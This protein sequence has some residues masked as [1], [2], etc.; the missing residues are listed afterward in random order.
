MVFT[1]LHAGGIG[2]DEILVSVIIAAAVGLL[3]YWIDRNRADE[4]VPQPDES[5]TEPEREEDI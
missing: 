4:A 2:W 5:L 3:A 1:I